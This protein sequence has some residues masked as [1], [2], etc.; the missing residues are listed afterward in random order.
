MDT[1][2]WKGVNGYFF[3]LRMKKLPFNH[4]EVGAGCEGHLFHNYLFYC[5]YFLT[6]ALFVNVILSYHEILLLKI[7]LSLEKIIAKVTSRLICHRYF[8]ILRKLVN[9]NF[10]EPVFRWKKYLPGIIIKISLGKC[11]FTND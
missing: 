4:W 1:S 9:Q 11:L 8:I 3:R 10:I 6:L 5:F 7:L 2:M